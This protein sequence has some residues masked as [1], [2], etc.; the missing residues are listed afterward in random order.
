[1]EKL[2]TYSYA[3][4]PFSEDFAGCISWGNFGNQILRCATQHATEHG[5]GYKQ[6]IRFHHAWVLSRLA[7]EM[8][9]MPQTGESFSISTWVSRL[10]H[11]FTDRHFCIARPDGTV[12][13]NA[14]S[15]W[16]L[17]DTR[18][19]MPA[20]LTQLPDGGFT[21]VLMPERPA[22]VAPMGR[23]RLKNPALAHTHRAAYTDLDI[24]GHVNSIRYIELLLNSFPAAKLKEHQPSRIEVAYCLEAF[25]GDLLNVYTGTDEKNPSRNLF[26]IRKDE[27]ETVVKASIT[28]S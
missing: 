26:E 13:G 28:L 10:Y 9:A 15:I 16:A 19:R 7:I 22:P 17:I 1:M 5:F 21:N 12:I 11:Q 4:E 23:I 25:D 20:D 27:T 18:T 3:V 24:N 6:M 8:K 2:S 14:S